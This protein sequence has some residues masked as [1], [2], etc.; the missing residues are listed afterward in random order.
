MSEDRQNGG[1]LS[2]HT[3]EKY[4]KRLCGQAATQL[5]VFYGNTTFS[6]SHED[7]L[8]FFSSV[9]AKLELICNDQVV[10]YKTLFFPPL[11]RSHRETYN[12]VNLLS[13]SI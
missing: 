2:R 12:L 10:L 7:E 4:P 11:G 5:L 6:L 1:H 3:V 8:G 13:L 9:S